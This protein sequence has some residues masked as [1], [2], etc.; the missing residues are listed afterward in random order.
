MISAIDAAD[1]RL[2]YA[3]SWETFD[4]TFYYVNYPLKLIGDDYRF[5]VNG[6]LASAL[7][8]FEDYDLADNMIVVVSNLAGDTW[9]TPITPATVATTFHR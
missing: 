5:K 2:A 3:I 7:D 9:N 4:Y 1:P 6:T 8:E